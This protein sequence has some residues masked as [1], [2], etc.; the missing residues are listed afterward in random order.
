MVVFGNGVLRPHC[1][2]RGLREFKSG[3]TSIMKI[4]PLRPADQEHV[5]TV[6]VVELV[7]ENHEDTIEDLV[8]ALE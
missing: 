7:L 8:F 2:G 4:T 5:K 6:Q 3:L 1:F